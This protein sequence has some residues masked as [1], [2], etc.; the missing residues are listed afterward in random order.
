VLDEIAEMPLALQAKMLRFLEEKTFRR[1]GGAADEIVA[2]ITAA[3]TISPSGNMPIK[4][5]YPMVP[6]N[7][8]VRN[9]K[10]L[11]RF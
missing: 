1:V 10:D 6:L 8:V 5:K 3:N 9:I 11:E 4:G 7:S 2:A